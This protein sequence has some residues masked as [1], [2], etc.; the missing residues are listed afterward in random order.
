M[1]G[2]ARPALGSAA[3]DIVAVDDGGHPWRLADHRGRHLV[4]I[5]HRHIH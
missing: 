4:I 3:P 5:F 1:N 2:P